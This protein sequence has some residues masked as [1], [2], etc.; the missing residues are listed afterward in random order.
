MGRTRIE[1]SGRLIRPPTLGVT[2]SGRA[3]LRLSVDCGEERDTLLLEIVVMDGAA[4]DLART[5]SAGQR[6]RAAGSL[7]AVRRGS[8]AGPGYQ[9]LKVLAS[10]VHPEPVESGSAKETD[11]V[12][13]RALFPAR[14]QRR[15]KSAKD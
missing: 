1:F 4:R 3:V 2:P 9:Q 11:L 15:I 5:L 13:R 12:A 8:L 7:K 6:I 10:E 14:F